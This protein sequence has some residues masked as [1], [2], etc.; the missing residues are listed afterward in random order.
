VVQSDNGLDHDGH[1]TT[2]ESP[3]T[4]PL[5]LPGIEKLPQSLTPLLTQY[6]PF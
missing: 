6:S 4:Q 3:T 2:T 1:D 5:T